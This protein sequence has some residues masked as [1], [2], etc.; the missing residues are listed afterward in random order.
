MVH[1]AYLRL[2]VYIFH[3][4]CLPLE[5]FLNEDTGDICSTFV[6]MSFIP[7]FFFTALPIYL[8]PSL[9]SPPFSP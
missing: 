4:S 9:P 6:N 2:L 3:D 5:Y 1:L 8:P 7:T